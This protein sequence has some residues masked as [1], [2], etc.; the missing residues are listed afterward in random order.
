MTGLT[1]EEVAEY[2][3]SVALAESGRTVPLALSTPRRGK[4]PLHWACLL[5]TS[6]RHV[7][8]VWVPSRTEVSTWQVLSGPGVRWQRVRG[9]RVPTWPGIIASDH[10]P[11]IAE[12]TFG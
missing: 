10:S 9:E 3:E 8:Y 12:F 2:A 5:Y 11:V 1:P 7:D 4:P 6:A